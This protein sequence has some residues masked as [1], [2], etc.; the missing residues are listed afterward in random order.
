MLN[1]VNIF[2]ALFS[3][4]LIYLMCCV[5]SRTKCL[6]GSDWNMISWFFTTTQSH[7]TNSTLKF[8]HTVCQSV[9]G[10]VHL[11]FGELHTQIQP[12]T[13]S[14]AH[15]DHMAVFWQ[16]CHPQHSETASH[17]H[18]PIETTRSSE[19][20][21]VCTHSLSLLREVWA[22]GC[23]RAERLRMTALQESNTLFANA[24]AVYEHSMH[25]LGYVCVLKP[26]L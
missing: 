21:C 22:T 20:V 5:D 26:R 2:I 8:S 11:S 16:A 7:L 23:E 24:N 15:D 1:C 6:T 3:F 14:T 12:R 18:L 10:C 25:A 4:E 13:S 17:T 19:W 9:S